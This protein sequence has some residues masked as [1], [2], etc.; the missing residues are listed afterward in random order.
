MKHLIVFTIFL[1]R[2]AYPQKLHDVLL[3]LAY[4]ILMEGQILINALRRD[5]L[6]VVMHTLYTKVYTNLVVIFTLLLQKVFPLLE[7]HTS[8]TKR[9]PRWPL[10]LMSYSSSTLI[11]LH[12]GSTNRY[13]NI[14]GKQL[15]NRGKFYY[16]SCVRSSLIYTALLCHSLAL[17]ETS[18]IM[19]CELLTYLSITVLMCT[20][21]DINFTYQFLL[22]MDSY[23]IIIT[24][25][26]L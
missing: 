17:R 5:C 21:N 16:D 3:A 20:I 1:Y 2:Y 19:Q 11:N 24:L 15:T 13:Y 4:Q 23:K 6:Q 22:Q 8:K 25:L 26:L 9:Y 18:W 12:W 7:Q 10:P 14:N